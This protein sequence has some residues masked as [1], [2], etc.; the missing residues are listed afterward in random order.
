MFF[1]G[2]EN[3]S[4]KRFFIAQYGPAER[5][6]YLRCGNPERAVSFSDYQEACDFLM[7]LE[8]LELMGKVPHFEALDIVDENGKE[9]YF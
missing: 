6:V 1:I 9:I 8:N 4:G 7:Y 3:S 5:P 2:C